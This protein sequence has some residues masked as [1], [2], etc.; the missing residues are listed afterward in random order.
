MQ[1]ASVPSVNRMS[2]DALDQL[3]DWANRLLAEARV[4]HLGLLD[5]NEHPRVL[6]VTY[7]LWDG[8]LWSAI[9]RKPKR[10]RPARLRFLERRPDASLTVDRYE[11]EWTALAWVQVLGRVEILELGAAEAEGALA[12]LT[13]K[14]G[15]YRDERPPGPLLRFM[16][17]RALCWQAA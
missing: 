9:D 3:P 5:D 12:A 15:Q 13:E 8:A 16:P 6:P 11:E 1:A 7:A 4:G 10:R 2:S 17:R 14:Y